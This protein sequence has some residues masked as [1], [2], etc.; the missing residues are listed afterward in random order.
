TQYKSDQILIYVNNQLVAST[1]YIQGNPVGL[2]ICYLGGDPLQ[3]DTTSGFYGAIDELQIKS[4]ALVPTQ[5]QQVARIAIVPPDSATKGEEVQLNFD[6]FPTPFKILSGTFEYTWGGSD[7]Y[8]SKS[9]AFRD[10]IF[11][12][13]FQITMPSDSI[14][15]RGIKY[16]ISLQTDYGAV[17]YP[18]FGQNEGQYSWIEVKTPQEISAV[19]LP[20]KI[21]RMI[22]IPYVLDIPAIDA[23]LIDN[24]GAADPYNWRVFDWIQDDTNYVA[25][26]DSSWRESGG[27]RQGKALW[28]ITSQYQTFD[29]G[30][31]RS[32]ENVNYRI[33]L[34]HGWNMI[35]NPFPYVVSWSDVEKTSNFISDPIYR[36][37]S[38]SIGWIYNVEILNPWDGYFIWNGDSSSR[39]L[40]VAPKEALIRPLTKQNMLAHKYLFKYP[41]VSIL[42][43][44]EIRCGKF[45]DLDNLFGIAENASDE[46]DSYDLKEAPAMG[47][48]ISLWIDN[49]NWK[50]FSGDYTVDIR[51]QGSEGYAWN[52]VIDY[53]IEKPEDILTMKFKRLTDLPE[54]WLMYLFDLSE[55][56]AINLKDQTEISLNPGSGIQTRKPYKFVIGTESF[57]LQSSNN[58]PLIPL[59]FE[60]FQNYPNPF[61]AATTIS[62]NLPKRMH[63]TVK[64]YNILGQLVKTL[65]DE[66]VRGG[67]H[68]IY[69]DG[70]NNQG[71]LIST[72][73]YI[74][75]VQTKNYVA[76]KKLLLIK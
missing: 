5:M 2:P 7:V 57:V 40:I 69:W 68:K 76:V 49:R 73:L 65:V 19:S 44:A 29:A 17:I 14:T 11:N 51:K 31:G 39:S 24:L 70:K 21:H 12:S 27:F 56:M 10:S 47:D 20:Q 25:Y 23:I 30:S 43:S 32:P 37:T 45:I 42:I 38:D 13:P 54:N 63:I 8:H 55:D 36:S 58:I 34:E 48:Y 72:G 61:N 53:S 9:L 1:S 66:Q 59:E 41:D 6:I 15:V 46:Y 16:R 22:S 26:G 64:I 52:I 67:N 18:D 28:L 4:T 62:F 71:N 3:Q 75:R 33:N 60:L 50:K 74:V 35:G